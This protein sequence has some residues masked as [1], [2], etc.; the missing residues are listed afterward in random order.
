MSVFAKGEKCEL[1]VR[2]ESERELRIYTDAIMRGDTTKYLFTGSTPMRW[3]DSA[4]VWKKEREAGDVLFG[5]WVESSTYKEWATAHQFV[6][7]CGL[8]SH[9]DIYKSWELRILIFDKDAI[10]KGIGFEACSLMVDYAF[11]RLNAHRVWLGVNADNE[12]AINCYKK[13][14]FKEEGRLR[15]EIFYH[16]KYV[17]AV[18]MGILQNEWGVHVEA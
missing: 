3:I 8:H 16:G 5:I 18:R 15:D 1:R 7:I 9:R 14:G 17:D 2:E 11:N 12:L 4:A 10:G 13:V 6:G